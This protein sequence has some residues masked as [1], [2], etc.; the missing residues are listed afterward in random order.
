MACK[1]IYSMVWSGTACHGVVWY[2]TMR[3]SMVC[4]CAL[5]PSWCYPEEQTV[6]CLHCLLGTASRDTCGDQQSAV[7]VRLKGRVSHSWLVWFL[8]SDQNLKLEIK[9]YLTTSR[10]QFPCLTVFG[11]KQWASSFANKSRILCHGLMGILE[12]K[13]K[14]LAFWVRA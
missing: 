1:V 13:G 6:K 8:E 7:A 3:H 11:F 14:G 5:T 2:S 9:L 10:S 4:I 12:G